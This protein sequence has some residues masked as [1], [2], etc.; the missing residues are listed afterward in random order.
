MVGDRPRYELHFHACVEGAVVRDYNNVTHIFQRSLARFTAVPL[1]QLPADLTDFT[2]RQDELEQVMALLQPTTPSGET[3]NAICATAK[4][5]TIASIAGMAGVGKSALAIHVA[6]KLKP[7][8]PDAQ[9]YVNLRGTENQPVEPLEVLAGFLR[10]L[11]VND[12]SMPVELTERSK[13]YRSLL[14]GKRVL[15]L[16]DNAYDEAQVRPLLPDN[17]S[18]AVLITSRRRQS[19]LQEAAAFDLGVMKEPEALQLLQRLVGVERTQGEPEAATKIINLCGRF[20]LA[21]RIAGGMLRNKPE[22]RLEECDRQL[23]LE[24][25]DLAPLRLSNLDVRASFASSFKQLDESSAR[26]FRLLGLLKGAN[27]A[28][29]IAAALLES[30]SDTALTSL[31]SLVNVQLLEPAS[32]GRYRLHDLVRLF[33]KEQ[34]AQ[35]EPAEARQ[36]ARLRAARWYLEMSQ[37]M[38]LALKPETRHQLARVLVEGKH[39]SL[40]ATEQNWFSGALNWFQLERM[41]LLASV[42][43]AYQSQAWDVNLALVRNLVNFFNVY[44]YRADWERTHLL[45]LEASRMLGEPPDSEAGASRQGE[46]QTLTNLGNVYALQNDWAKARECYE[47]S[48]VIF[49]ELGNHLE[50]AKTIGNLAN[51]YSQQGNWEKAS[52]CYKQSLTTFV[53]L[54]DHYAEAQTLA[55]MGIFYIKQGQEEEAGVLWQQAIKKLPSDSLKSKRVAEWLELIQKPNSVDEADRGS[56]QESQETSVKQWTLLELVRNALPWLWKN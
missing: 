11:G 8:F 37:I 53:E 54:K 34:L 48:Q 49:D 55:N 23:A 32:V 13:L 7:S 41:N 20:P 2:G 5:D 35:E 50:V 24:R 26:L 16:L 33:A 19:G 9:L 51:V 3:A 25:Q 36:A 10:A 14:S 28:P 31:Q 47:Q 52:E 17:S 56:A 4:R 1:H 27:F 38:N 6:Y 29:G 30:E 42:E 15:V 21:I 39:Q 46:A 18:C 44:A 12:Q 22:W 40:E 45:A 43:W